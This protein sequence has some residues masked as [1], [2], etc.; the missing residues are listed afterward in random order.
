MVITKICMLLCCSFVV[1][2]IEVFESDDSRSITCLSITMKT[3]FGNHNRV[4]K[5]GCHF[6]KVFSTPNSKRCS[7]TGIRSESSILS[8]RE[9]Y[10]YQWTSNEILSS[11]PARLTILSTVYSV[12]PFSCL[13]SSTLAVISSHHADCWCVWVFLSLLTRVKTTSGVQNIWM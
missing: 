4:V 3:S 8:I 5:R 9:V 2:N 12:V 1:I 6:F 11:L 10:L 13:V 7:A